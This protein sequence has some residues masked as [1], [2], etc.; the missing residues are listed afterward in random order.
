MRLPLSVAIL[1]AILRF[2]TTLSIPHNS[3]I[4]QLPTFSPP[5]PPPPALIIATPSRRGDWP[6]TPW[7]Y[8]HYPILTKFEEYGRHISNTTLTRSVIASTIRIQENIIA[9]G[10]TPLGRTHSVAFHNGIITLYMVFAPGA[11]ITREEVFVMLDCWRVYVGAFGAREIAQGEMG[12]ARPW[13]PLAAFAIQ[14]DGV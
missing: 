2:S 7:T 5:T 10:Q 8:A 6:D 9:K 3:S 12:V 14:F 4:L 13:R 1:P 11:A